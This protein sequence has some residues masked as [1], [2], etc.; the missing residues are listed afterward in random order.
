MLQ[1]RLSTL[2][3]QRNGMNLTKYTPVNTNIRTSKTRFYVHIKLDSGAEIEYCVRKR[4]LW[5]TRDEQ[6][7]PTVLLCYHQKHQ[8]WAKHQRSGEQSVPT[9]RADGGSRC[10]HKDT[11]DRY[12]ARPRRLISD[13]SVTQLMVREEPVRKSN[14]IISWSWGEI[15]HRSATLYTQRLPLFADFY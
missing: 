4:K 14:T 7:N 12:R 5:S 10:H 1:V 9:I 15:F 11:D 8:L 3:T 2:H 13:R 6:T